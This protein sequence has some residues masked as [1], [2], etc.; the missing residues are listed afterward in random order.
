MAAVR[1][2]HMPSHGPDHVIAWLFC[3][4]GPAPDLAGYRRA[5]CD[6]FTSDQW[7][8]LRP[9]FHITV[10]YGKQQLATA[11]KGA[12]AAAMPAT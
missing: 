7:Q 9:A 1:I 11:A 5:G 8:P 6:N 4:A 10:P 3:T 12:A 2:Q